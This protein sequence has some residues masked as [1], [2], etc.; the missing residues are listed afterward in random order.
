MRTI[1][2][3]VC[4]FAAFAA[5]ATLL[6]WPLPRHLSTHLTASPSGDAGVYVWNLWVFRHELVEHGQLPLYTSRV[7]PLT[8]RADLSLHNYTVATNVLALPVLPRLGLIRT[9]NL[10]YLLQLAASGYGVFLLAHFVTT[11][12]LRAVRTGD[13]MN[14]A[15]ARKDSSLRVVTKCASRNTP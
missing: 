5:L 11:R 3:H 1:A 10:L 8:G 2:R 13:A 12:R 15:P 7:F 14:T 9:F 4:A 6:S